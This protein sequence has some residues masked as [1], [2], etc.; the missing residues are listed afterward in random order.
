MYP[1]EVTRTP[2]GETN[3]TWTVT[4]KAHIDSTEEWRT[5]DGDYQNTIYSGNKTVNTRTFSIFK[6]VILYSVTI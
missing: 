5:S 6:N 4:Y 1:L 3:A 2:Y